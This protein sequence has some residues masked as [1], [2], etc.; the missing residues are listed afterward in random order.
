MAKVFNFVL[1][2]MGLLLLL[3][4]AGFPTASNHVLGSLGITTT[5]SAG[6]ITDIGISN[7]LG[8]ILLVA[9]ILIFTLS[10]ATGGSVQIGTFVINTTDSRLVAAL[11]ASLIGFV[12]IDLYSVFNVAKSFGIDWLTFL[13]GAL[14]FPLMAAFGIA[15]VQWWRGSDI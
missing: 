3:A 10:T 6:I 12:E 11:C 1:I 13:C 4:F 15:L 7:I 14:I 2:L 8:S 5:S 9:I